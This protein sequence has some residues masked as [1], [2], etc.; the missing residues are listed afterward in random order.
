MAG[1]LKRQLELPTRKKDSEGPLNSKKESKE[2][3][4]GIDN[5]DTTDKQDVPVPRSSLEGGDP[6]GF[7]SGE[8][9]VKRVR[10]GRDALHWL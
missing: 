9:R 6:N 3:T 7:D 10:G 2:H 8:R 4:K 1:W 5:K